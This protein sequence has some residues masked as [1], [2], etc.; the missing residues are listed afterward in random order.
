MRDHKCGEKDDGREANTYVLMNSSSEGSAHQPQF[1][2]FVKLAPVV[3]RCILAGSGGEVGH[4]QSAELLMAVWG[5]GHEG[6]PFDCYGE[7]SAFP[8][9]H[10]ATESPG[11]GWRGPLGAVGHTLGHGL[12]PCIRRCKG[13]QATAFLLKPYRSFRYEVRSYES[14]LLLWRLFDGHDSVPSSS[15]SRG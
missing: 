2:I 13:R 6:S 11:R 7:T 12:F 3:S 5:G 10:Q 14:D 4:I 15:L 1:Y 8:R 9:P